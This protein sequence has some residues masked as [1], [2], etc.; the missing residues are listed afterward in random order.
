MRF[1]F[2]LIYKFAALISP[3]VSCPNQDHPNPK[4]SP[5]MLTYSLHYLKVIH[6]YKKNI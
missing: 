6:T 4:S 5:L 2:S 1:K 3:S